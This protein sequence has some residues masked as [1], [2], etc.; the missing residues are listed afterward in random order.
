MNW[1]LYS[2]GRN[3][4]DPLDGPQSWSGCGGGK[5]SLPCPFQEMD[6]DH[7]AHS[8]VTIPI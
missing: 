8:T 5:K 3:H 7:P 4:W 1:P 6:P 2:W